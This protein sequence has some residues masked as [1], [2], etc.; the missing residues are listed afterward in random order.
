MNIVLATSPAGEDIHGVRSIPPLSLGY[1]AASLKQLPDVH[2]RVLDAYGEGLTVPQAAERA[3]ALSP[4]L[5]AVSSTSFC[6]K[7]GMGLI[8]QTKAKKGDLVS[9]MGGYHP[10]TFDYLLLRDLPFLDFVIRGEGDRSFPELCRRLSKCESVAGLPGL[11]YRE[12]GQVVRGDPQQIEDLDSLPF[13]AR[14]LFTYEGYFHQFGGF[15]LPPMPP[16]ANM[17]TSRGCPYHCTFCPKMFPQWHYRLRSAENV[18]E[19]IL[20]LY[21]AGCEMAFFQDENFSHSIP[22]IERLCNLILDHNLQMRFAFQGTIH[23]IPESVF[24][25][26]HKAGFDALLVGIESGS[27][28]QLKRFGKPATSRSLAEGVQRAK[29]AHMAVVGFFIFGAPGETAQDF[30]ATQNFIR[31]TRPHVCGGVC[32]SIH[33]QA[34]LWHELIGKGEPE[35]LDDSAPVPMDTILGHHNEM[36]IRQRRKGFKQA[37]LRSWLN[38]TRLIDVFDLFIYNPT[39]RRA[40]N[41]TIKILIFSLL[42]GFQR[43]KKIESSGCAKEIDILRG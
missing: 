29:K 34:L 12:N 6:F 37:F 2:I 8:S 26:M 41:N 23:H 11:S 39:I 25:L 19:E 10:T 43:K 1:L 21:N 42:R 22:R 33:P 13:P 30:E 38:W 40:M 5:L 32:L 3:L 14:E 28:A 35:N 16:T 24:Q 7:S 27:D 4:D 9:V 18:F 17:I 36:T 31:A 15:C 20:E